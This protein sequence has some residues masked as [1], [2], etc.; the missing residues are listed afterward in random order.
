MPP[1][2]LVMTGINVSGVQLEKK[3]R[4]RRIFLPSELKARDVRRRITEATF[5]SI[6]NRYAFRG[7]R[8]AGLLVVVDFFFP[9]IEALPWDP[10]K[11]FCVRAPAIPEMRL[12]TKIGMI[13]WVKRLPAP[14]ASELRDEKVLVTPS[15][16]LCNPNPVAPPPI[17]MR[18][19]NAPGCKICSITKVERIRTP[20]EIICIFDWRFPM[21]K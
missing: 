6:L 9:Q 14:L 10:C 4:E 15:N 11:F 19:T 17:D 12:A 21:T 2:E 20:S 16:A 3:E 18:E 7:G 8:V 13:P 1:I 5:I